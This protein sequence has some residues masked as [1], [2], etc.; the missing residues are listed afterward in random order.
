MSSRTQIVRGVDKVI[1]LNPPEEPVSS[2]HLKIFYSCDKP[3]A[4]QLDC[5]AAF[6]TGRTSTTSLRHWSC[7]P[8]SPKIRTLKLILPDW[9]VYQPDGIVPDSQWVLSCILR[10]SVRYGGFDDIEES[11][12]DQDVATLQPK[13][14]LRRP[15]KQHK[16]CFAW[17]AQM[18]RVTQQ[19][20]RKQCSW[21]QGK[22]RK[23]SGFVD[24][25]LRR[26]LTQQDV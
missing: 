8:G 11:I 5:I 21:E 20:S 17:S 3:S 16:L 22:V 4:V 14:P 7:V 2:H 19:C 9:L 1:L 23:V 25:C 6:D 24:G 13:P 15:V 26:V 12:L 10:V 18:L